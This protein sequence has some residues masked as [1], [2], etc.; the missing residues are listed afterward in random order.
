MS[1]C[2]FL[3]TEV[4]M[5]NIVPLDKDDS[6]SITSQNDIRN[7]LMDPT[8]Q[9]SSSYY[10]GRILLQIDGTLWLENV[11]LYQNLQLYKDVV[12][13]LSL[14]KYL[15]ENNFAKYDNRPLENLYTLCKSGGIKLPPSYECKVKKFKEVR[16]IQPNWAHLDE[17]MFNNVYMI[18]VVDPHEFYVRLEKFD[19]L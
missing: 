8:N 15:L 17:D 12:S 13:K 10:S 6:W 19:C 3:G 11:H 18:N 1:K 7:L 14:K 9:N 4:I 2:N 5:A 16:Q